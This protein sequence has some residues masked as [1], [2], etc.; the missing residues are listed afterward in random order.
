MRIDRQVLEVRH[1]RWVL[2]PG[3]GKQEVKQCKVRIH[4]SFDYQFVSAKA[5]NV[6]TIAALILINK[7]GDI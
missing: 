6:A 4:G 3:I 2:R 1:R 7:Q 5:S